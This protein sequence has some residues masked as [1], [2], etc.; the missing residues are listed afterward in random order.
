MQ[1]SKAIEQERA[2]RPIRPDE[3]LFKGPNA[4][5]RYEETD[6]YFAHRDLPEGHRLPEGELLSALHAYI[7]K[8]YSRT[9]ESGDRE[10]SGC[11]DETALIALGIL[12]EETTKGI[13]GETG[14]FALV[15]GARSDEE[16]TTED[17]ESAARGVPLRKENKA[18]GGNRRSA[19]TISSGSS[20]S[21]WDLSPDGPG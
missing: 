21:E 7:S 12:L 1:S 5:T 14:D 10:A 8:L 16:Y 3:V 9:Q 11:M 15:E 13:L 17:E 18:G 2:L 4:P 19:E 20:T 6:Y